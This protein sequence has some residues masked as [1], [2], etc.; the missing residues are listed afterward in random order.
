MKTT[1]RY[2]E[3][4]NFL[5]NGFLRSS[6]LI[7]FSTSVHAQGV[8]F[9][10]ITGTNKYDDAKCVVQTYDSGYVVVGSTSGLGSGQSDVYLTKISKNGKVLWQHGLGGVGVEKGNSLIQTKDSGFAI[11]GYSNSSGNGG[12]DVYLAKTDSSGNLLWSNTYGGFDWDF[13]NSI[14]ETNTGNYVIAGTTYSYGNGNGDVYLLK[15]DADGILL[16]D[17]AYGGSLEDVGNSVCQAAD[18]TYMVTGTT[19]SFGLGGTDVYLIK[20][21]LNGNKLW[22]KSYG[23]TANDVGNESKL[24]TGSGF[25]VIGSSNSFSPKGFYENWMI[26]TDSYG[27]SMWTRRDT[28]SF[29]RFATSIATTS[30]GGYIYTG[31]DDNSAEY[32]MYLYK[33]DAA[34]I[35]QNY[36]NYGGQQLENAF[37]VKQTYDGGYVVVGVTES[38]GDG[39]PNIYVLKTGSNLIS[40]GT[41]LIVVSTEEN[42]TPHETISV[43]PNP[44]SDYFTIEET[45]KSTLEIIDPLGR[46]LVTETINQG[47]NIVNTTTLPNGIYFIQLKNSQRIAFGKIIIRH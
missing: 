42:I 45:K 9:E 43:Y 19:K 8:N 4:S 32:N 35:F 6:C 3:I 37:S 46:T 22:S 28:A 21:D 36:R 11:T 15:T 38:Y 25:I 33:T 31:H 5:I 7:L 26:R 41:V 47:K 2:S 12:Y 10:L 13:G 17:S 29:N 16:W 20:S 39:K 23:S 14:I 44:A 1:S 24:T 27:D 34:G 30:D 18:G 40:T